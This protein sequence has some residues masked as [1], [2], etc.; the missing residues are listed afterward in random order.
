MYV[1]GISYGAA[2]TWHEYLIVDH[3]QSGPL[4]IKYHGNQGKEG[5]TSNL[6]LFIS[7]RGGANVKKVYKLN[8]IAKVYL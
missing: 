5:I 6:V 4:Y 1:L 8:E 3:K 2:Q 7:R